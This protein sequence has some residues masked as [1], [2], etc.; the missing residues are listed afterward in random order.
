MPRRKRDG[1]GVVAVRQR[2]AGVGTGRQRGRDAGNDLDTDPV[3]NQV[4]RLFRAAT[5]EI[6]VPALQPDDAFAF[7]G[8][9]G[10]QL[11]DLVLLHHV[12]A[13]ALARV[14]LL[15]VRVAERENLGRYQRVIDEHIAAGKQFAATNGHQARVSRTGADQVYPA[16][17]G[18]R[19]HARHGNAVA[20]VFNVLRIP[21]HGC[22]Q[23]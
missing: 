3:L 6:R 22:D 4:Q 5:E 11:V 23:D 16:V 15:G 14:D 17:R 1:A 10:E 19:I 8:F 7:L 21:G 18:F 9:P 2:Y 13:A 12:L 20:G